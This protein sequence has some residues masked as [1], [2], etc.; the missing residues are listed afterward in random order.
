MKPYNF[1]N[2][3]GDLI[4]YYRDGK[5]ANITDIRWK[6]SDD[7]LSVKVQHNGFY[8]FVDLRNGIM[9]FDHDLSNTKLYSGLD[10]KPGEPDVNYC[11]CEDGRTR[12]KCQAI[13]ID[14]KGI[15]ILGGKY[16]WFD[17]ID[18]RDNICHQYTK[19]RT[20]DR[21]IILRKDKDIIFPHKVKEIKP[22]GHCD[23]TSVNIE[24]D[25]WN[26]IDKDGNYMWKEPKHLDFYYGYSFING[27]PV[28][29]FEKDKKILSFDIYGNLISNP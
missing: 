7:V 16:E 24:E 23:Y 19:G 17:I 4:A 27:N 12:Y 21:F 14:D 29:R 9:M 10:H 11:I 8:N 20:I 5:I 13:R 22:F 6:Y 26:L 15:E 1:I 18:I 25:L 2:K 3:N 28:F